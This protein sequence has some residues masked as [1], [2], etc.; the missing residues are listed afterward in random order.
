MIA[1]PRALRVTAASLGAAGL[2]AC[3]VGGDEVVLTGDEDASRGQGEDAG[4]AD[5]P[6]TVDGG[7]RDTRPPIEDAGGQPQDTGTAEDVAT[8][9]DGGGGAD[10]SATADAGEPDPPDGLPRYAVG[11]RH[12]PLTPAVVERL[13]EVPAPGAQADVFAK[14]GASITVSRNFMHCFAGGHVDLAGRDALQATIDHFLAGDAGGTDPFTRDSVSATVGWSAGAA[15]AGEPSPLDREVAALAPV[16][17][18]IMYGTNDIQ[19]RSPDRY[20]DQLLTL[21][22][23]LLGYGV[24]PLLSTIPP[25]DDDEWA[26]GQVPVYNALVRAAAQ[27]RLVPLVDFHAELAALPDHGLGPDGIHPTTYRPGGAARAC[28]LTAEGL[29]SGYNVRNLITLEALD[30]LRQTLLDGR[31]PPDAAAPVLEGDGSPDEPFRIA[32]LPFSDLRDTTDS[33]WRRLN[34]YSGCDADQDESGPEW[35]YRLELER[36]VRL[37][38]V[39]T[40]RGD[41]DVDVHLLSA[42]GGEADCVD[43]AHTEASAEVGPGTVWL[44]VDS[45]VSGGQERT[46]EYLL[47]V[48]GEG[49][50]EGEGEGAQPFSCDGAGGEVN[51]ALSEEPGDPGCPD[52]MARVDDFCID[53]FEGALIERLPSG[54]EAPWSPYDNP[55]DRE[56]RAVSLRGAV[57]QGY[58]HG[59]QAAGA[60]ARAGKRQCTDREWLRACQGAGE[61]TYPYGAAHEPG[62]CN[63]SRAIH[64]AVEAFP[65]DPTPYDRIQDACINQL[66]EGLA[67]TGAYGGCTTAE[68][69]ADLMGNL[70][71][72]TADPDGTFRGGFYVDTVRNGPGC[73]YRTTAHNRWHWDYSTGFRCCADAL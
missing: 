44:A 37:R 39:V 72:W 65:D 29:R 60:C 9:H 26:D 11:R 2:A 38:A 19:Q 6:P 53:R 58:I 51:E 32:S 63:D 36:R 3:G 18:V 42:G 46:G 68:G 21:V 52:G 35:L 20:G 70:H 4:R 7:H 14:I 50:G 28:A 47:A 10:A 23:T 16:V 22:D 1:P 30:R 62:V 64:P 67:R 34:R 17:A 31:A 12:S 66:P 73:L 49:V 24:V 41:T 27:G 48:V 55:G 8:G 61:T 40:D 5:D 33:P 25:R 15:L 59:E 43:R 57:P 13:L 69:V 56:V 45:Y 54:E 71:E